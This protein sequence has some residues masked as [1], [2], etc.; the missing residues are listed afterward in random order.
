[1]NACILIAVISINVVCIGVD[2]KQ[3]NVCHSKVLGQVLQVTESNNEKDDLQSLSF[4]HRRV[5]RILRT[6]WIV[7]LGRS[8]RLISEQRTI[9]FVLFNYRRPSCK[10][11]RLIGALKA[12]LWIV[13]L[14]VEIIFAMGLSY[15]SL[16]K[17]SAYAGTPYESG[18]YVES[19][20]ETKLQSRLTMPNVLFLEEWTDIEWFY[21]HRQLE[22]LLINTGHI[23]LTIFG[24]TN[25]VVSVETNQN[26]L[27][28][29]GITEELCDID[30]SVRV[31]L[32]LCRFIRFNWYPALH[33]RWSIVIWT[34]HTTS[35]A[36]FQILAICTTE[37]SEN[38]EAKPIISFDS[39]VS[40]EKPFDA[41]WS[42]GPHDAWT[43]EGDSAFDARTSRVEVANAWWWQTWNQWISAKTQ[44]EPDR[45]WF[46]IDQKEVDLR[47][48]GIYIAEVSIPQVQGESLESYI[49]FVALS[50]LVAIAGCGLT[51]DCGSASSCLS[52]CS[53]VYKINGLTR[54]LLG[55]YRFELCLRRLLLGYYGFELCLK[56][57][58]H[59]VSFFIYQNW[60]WNVMNLVLIMRFSAND[61]I[62]AV[63]A[64]CHVLK[65]NYGFNYCKS[66]YL[67][68][69]CKS[70]GQS[71]TNIIKASVPWA[72]GFHGPTTTH[73]FE[74]TDG[75]DRLQVIQVF[76]KSIFEGGVR[77]S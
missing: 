45:R 48:T 50:R 39:A 23:I 46:H 66:R 64:E 68:G 41:V 65:P 18:I 4:S 26:L 56:I 34:M 53:S 13:M 8:V 30:L 7:R 11:F 1:M 16:V 63:C 67:L 54:L 75:W 61:G 40:E 71:Y 27:E 22:I 58:I 62:G 74:A 29:S 19:R 38:A 25:V 77:V 57:C 36:S 17:V 31:F 33:F 12:M 21:F 49:I 15:M 59:G 69:W 20:S 5:H 24:V 32:V 35:N 73:C 47:E 6:V 51:T 72:S 10:M 28:H 3:C 37:V 9:I 76:F 43:S 52:A 2:A 55:L 44:W 14:H 60:Y 42:E 70:G